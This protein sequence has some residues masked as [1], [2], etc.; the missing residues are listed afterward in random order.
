MRAMEEKMRIAEMN[1]WL[2]GGKVYFL[3]RP[4]GQQTSAISLS[5]S[6]KQT[7]AADGQ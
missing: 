6:V 7:A 3:Y 4:S 2:I 1:E 5:N